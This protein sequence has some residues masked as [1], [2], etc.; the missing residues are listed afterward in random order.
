[1]TSSQRVARCVLVGLLLPGLPV[2]GQVKFGEVSTNLSG[3]VSAGYTADYGNTTSSDHSLTAGGSGTLSG[4]FYSPGF[5]SFAASYFLNQSRANSSFQSISDASGINLSTHIFG[6]SHFPGSITYSKTYNSEGNYSVPGLSNYV[7]HGDSD[8]LGIGWGEYLPGVPSFS[9][10][11]EMGSGTYS[12]Y[13]TNDE[14][15]NAF[16]SLNL[17]SG[18]RVAGFNMSGY[19][20][21]GG[22]HSLLPE[23][24]TGEP[25][26]ETHSDDT[27][28]GFNVNHRLPLN[29]SVTTSI[30]RSEYSS[31]YENYTTSG[32]IDMVNSSAGLHPT[33]KLSLSANANYSDNLSGQL[34]QS[35]VAAGGAAPG[36]NSNGASSSLDLEGVA[37]YTVDKNMQASAYVERRSQYF[38]GTD[39]VANSYGGSADYARQLLNGNFNASVTVT[40]TNSSTS[41]AN[42]LGF[43]TNANYYCEVRGWKVNGSLAYA[44]DVQTLLVTYMNSYYNYSGSARKRWGKL[45]FGAG[46]GGGRT[47]LTDQAGTSSGEQSY[48]ASLG[49]SPWITLNGTYSKTYGQA[50][51]TGAGLVAVP[52]PLPILPSSLVTLYGGD[53]YSFGL[54]SSPAKGLIIGASYSKSLS[55]TSVSGLASTNESDEYNAIIQYQVR[56]VQIVGGY[57]RLDQ[58]FSGSGTAPQNISS[59]YMGA[60]RW[61]KFF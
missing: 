48:N 22:G 2:A 54:G 42:S 27:A 53:S 6:G 43:S 45:N 33:S 26:E 15:G 34:V 50:L 38:L 36:L 12:V 18:Y 37:S 28:Y 17:H 10:A 40:G 56:K 9:A 4:F 59:Y 11:F 25:A 13:G 19:Y 55:N 57:S 41:S 3:A 29:G 30:N 1:V 14:G 21:N 23:I 8:T 44:Q 49:Y 31:Y 7:T 20:N 60:T 32:A 58:G 39:Y 5:L 61:F 47:A 51:A 46:A 24:V 35:V 52:V 16:H